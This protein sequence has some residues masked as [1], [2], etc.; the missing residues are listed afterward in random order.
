MEFK[1]ETRLFIKNLTQKNLFG[2]NH[3]FGTVQ[4]T[5]NRVLEP[6]AKCSVSNCFLNVLKQEDFYLLKLLL[7]FGRNK[8][9]KQPQKF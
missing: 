9:V 1:P 6:L 2:T 4:K 3:D 5:K 8:K 7:N